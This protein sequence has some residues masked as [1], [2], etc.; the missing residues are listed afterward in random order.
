M[1]VDEKKYKHVMESWAEWSCGDPLGVRG[2]PQTASFIQDRVD[3]CFGP[4]VPLDSYPILE[5]VDQY[6]HQMRMVD[7][8]LVRVLYAHW[9]AKK[10]WLNVCQDKKAKLLGMGLTAYKGQVA[11]ANVGVQAAMCIYRFKPV[12]RSE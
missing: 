10:Q 4:I 3:N 2:Y 11:R 5:Q 1:F 7:P 9:E 8:L 6:V 12:A